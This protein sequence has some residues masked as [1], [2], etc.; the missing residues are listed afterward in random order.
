MIIKIKCFFLGHDMV[1]Y[2]H[3]G[4]T[5]KICKRCLKR[6]VSDGKEWIDATIHI[7]QNYR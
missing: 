4:Y 5:S 6:M 2:Q 7:K 3:E 1:E